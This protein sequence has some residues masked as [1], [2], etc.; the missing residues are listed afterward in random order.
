M[1]VEKGI[2]KGIVVNYP[3]EIAFIDKKDKGVIWYKNEV[4]N[5]NC[6][7]FL[8]QCSFQIHCY[9]EYNHQ[10]MRII[11]CCTEEYLDI[12]IPNEY[13]FVSITPCCCEKLYSCCFCALYFNTCLSK[14]VSIQYCVMYCDG[15]NELHPPHRL[16][17]H[18]SFYEII[19]SIALEEA[20]ISHILN[21]EGEKIQKAVAI[22]N[23]IGELICVNES[24]KHTL[25]QVTML[26]GMLYSKLEAVVN[27]DVFL[28]CNKDCDN[29]SVEE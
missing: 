19:H 24:V 11:S 9:R 28:N 29:S 10:M 1:N 27:S 23:S 25:T 14:L 12:C 18:S 20:G 21:A 7:Y 3:C 22:S 17:D 26:E 6:L 8:F 2:E 5:P 4:N 15:S 13:K 16:P